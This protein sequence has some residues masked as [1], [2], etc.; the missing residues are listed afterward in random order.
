[1]RF[2]RT[3]G[4]VFGVWGLG[5]RGMYGLVGVKALKCRAFGLGVEIFL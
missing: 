4:F 2:C 1:M 5:F 3:Y